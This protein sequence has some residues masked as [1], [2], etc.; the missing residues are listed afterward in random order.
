MAS[1]LIIGGCWKHTRFFEYEIFKHENFIGW[2]TLRIAK[3]SIS[4]LKHTS[5][6]YELVQRCG[7]V[8]GEPIYNYVFKAKTVSALNIV[9]QK[10]L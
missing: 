5:S 8:F 3:V 1:L 9:E 2:Q 6:L 7:R 4:P 10:P